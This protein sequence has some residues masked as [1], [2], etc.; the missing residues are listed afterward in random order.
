MDAARMLE[1]TV[2]ANATGTMLPRAAYTSPEWFAAEQAA[3]HDRA[4][5][6]VGH[7]SQ[8]APGSFR[9]VRAGA[10]DLVV[11]RDRSGEL[12]AFHN[13]CRHRGAEVVL[14]DCGTAHSLVCPYHL[15]SYDLAGRL[16]V[17]HGMSADVTPAD[18]PLKSRTVREWHG[19]V[20]VLPEHDGLDSP[21]FEPSAKHPDEFAR[22]RLEEAQVV[23]TEMYDI[24]ASWMAVRENFTECYHCSANHPEL[25]AAYDLGGSYD[26]QGREI[27]AFPLK[28]GACSLS[29][30]GQPVCDRPFG[31]FV[32]VPTSEWAYE[33][34]KA[35]PAFIVIANP[36]HVVVFAFTPVAVDRTQLRCDWLVHGEAV[37]GIDFTTENV[38]KV[39]HETNLQDIGLCES[40]QRGMT[41]RAFEPGPLSADRE[42]GI[43]DLHTRYAGWLSDVAGQHATVGA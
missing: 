23:H 35:A 43:F 32:D 24:A 2:Q 29:L 39:W 1:L 15:W 27:D 11:T 12:H 25:L 20:F 21:D 40:A 28:E 16:K 36:D 8:L 26:D 10:D 30:D 5:T 4:W 38:V 33:F 41:S 14:K 34:A 22:Y 9:R 7:T 13:V 31:E 3:V 17:A 37:D 19:L 6:Y 18:Y 42:P